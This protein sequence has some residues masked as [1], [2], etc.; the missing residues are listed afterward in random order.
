MC[1]LLSLLI[2]TLSTSLIN[3]C[4]VLSLSGGG[5]YGAFEMSIASTLMEKYGGNWDILTGV[6][7][8]SINS[9]YLSTISKG[10]EKLFIED[11]KKLWLSTNNNQVYSYVFF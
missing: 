2:L 4:K 11:Y 3:S 7:A 5:A 6:S 8:G 1:K 10:D 9:A